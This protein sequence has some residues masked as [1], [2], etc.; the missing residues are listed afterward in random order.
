MA[1]ERT[2]RGPCTFRQRDLAAAVEAMRAAGVSRYR[3][4][5]KPGEIV[6][7]VDNDE[8]LSLPQDAEA[9]G[10]EGAEPL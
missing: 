5:L 6:V 8:E 1:G 7:I 9:T 2:P 4:K 10:W 3:I